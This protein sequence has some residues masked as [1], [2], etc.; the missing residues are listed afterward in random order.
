MAS[1]KAEAPQAGP[2][3]TL[4]EFLNHAARSSE[5]RIVEALAAFAREAST[6][7][8]RGRAEWQAAF[9]AFLHRPA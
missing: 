8:R 6:L 3:L 5:R 1:K 2:L 4:D 7:E 9:E